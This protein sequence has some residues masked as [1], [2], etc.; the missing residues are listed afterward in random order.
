LVLDA[1]AVL[2][3]A[4]GEPGAATVMQ[5][6]HGA[7]ISAV[8]HLEVVSALLRAGRSFDQV[9]VFLHE[10]F[11]AVVPFDLIQANVAAQLHAVTR[12]W[13]LS[14]A[15]CAC[16][17]LAQLRQLPVLTGDRDWLKAGV[18]VDVKLFR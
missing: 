16:L 13:D 15:D 6:R 10:L 7:M 4:N 11:P 18:D 3:L 5:A 14:Y 2:A 9:Q 12:R 17:A 8:N 1:S